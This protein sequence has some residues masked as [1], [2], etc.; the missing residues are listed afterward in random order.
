[1]AISFKT[2]ELIGLRELARSY[3]NI[4]S[5]LAEASVL[6]ACLTLPKGTIHVISDIHGEYKKLRHIINNAS[7]ALRNLVASLFAGRLSEDEQKRLLAVLYYPM[8]L[9]AANG[10][11]K[12]SDF[13]LKSS[14]SWQAC[15]AG[16]MSKNFFRKTRARFFR[17]CFPNRSRIVRRNTRKR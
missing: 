10:S 9:I 6:R 3:P 1:M 11:E 15:A 5:A 16:R 14:A 17:N 2:E 7:G 13:N 12:R 8:T 4:D